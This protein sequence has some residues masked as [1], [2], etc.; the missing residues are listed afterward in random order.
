MN[1][2]LKLHVLTVKTKIVATLKVYLNQRVITLCK[3]WSL[4]KHFFHQKHLPLQYAPKYAMHINLLLVDH[5]IESPLHTHKRHSTLPL[6]RMTKAKQRIFKQGF[7]HKKLGCRTNI[8]HFQ[9][10]TILGF[11]F[12]L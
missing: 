10:L 8:S 1:C 7:Y 11:L 12:H 2:I 6:I 5:N 4:H 9:R 3:K